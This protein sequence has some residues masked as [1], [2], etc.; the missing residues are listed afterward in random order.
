MVQERKVVHLYI[1][2][3]DTHKYYGSVAAMFENEG[4]DVIGIAYSSFR[5]HA[6]K[7]IYE[8]KNVIIRIGTLIQKRKGNHEE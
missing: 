3:T 8:N 1:K 4:K 5:A 7:N 6:G 2:A